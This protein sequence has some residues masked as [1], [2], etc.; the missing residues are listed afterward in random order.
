MTLTVL[1]LAPEIITL[2]FILIF[3]VIGRCFLDPIEEVD[4]KSELL[5]NKVVGFKTLVNEHQ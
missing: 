4:Q 3:V 2:A 5:A 1:E